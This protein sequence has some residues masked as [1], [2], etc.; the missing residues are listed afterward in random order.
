M[1]CSQSREKKEMNRLIVFENSFEAD[2]F[3]EAVVSIN[4]ILKMKKIKVR[5]KTQFIK[6]YESPWGTYAYYLRIIEEDKLNG[7]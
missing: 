2:G 1:Y 7:Q 6:D 4:E 3:D 5:V